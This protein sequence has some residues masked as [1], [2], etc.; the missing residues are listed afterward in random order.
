MYFSRRAAIII[1]LKIKN[2]YTINLVF[3]T[4]I[5]FFRINYYSMNYYLYYSKVVRWQAGSTKE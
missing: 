1:L 2:I 3:T 5:V 4:T